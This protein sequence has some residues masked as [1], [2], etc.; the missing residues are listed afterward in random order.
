M[1][2]NQFALI[3]GLK[4]LINNLVYISCVQC[5]LRIFTKRKNSYLIF[6]PV[7]IIK[8]Y[9]CHEHLISSLQQT[10]Q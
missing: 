3:H 10:A 2:K 6:Y 9:G 8:T 4:C 1:A 7:R 5:E